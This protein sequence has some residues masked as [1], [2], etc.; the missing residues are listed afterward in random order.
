MSIL[1]PKQS[2]RRAALRGLLGG[3]VVTAALPFLDAHLNANGTALA[4]TGAPL[5]LRLG[6]WYWG[7]GHTPGHAIAEKHETGPGIG[8]KEETQSLKSVEQWINHFSGF[9]MPLDGR[10]NYTHFTGWVANRTGSAPTRQGEIPAPTFDLL[11]GDVI[12]KNTRF[13]SLDVS[14]API[15]G[16]RRKLIR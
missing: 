1:L 12:G 8:F 2:T 14:V 5:P 7:M 10:Q 16:L 13:R 15:A 9:N 11:V 6:T 4:A 3:G